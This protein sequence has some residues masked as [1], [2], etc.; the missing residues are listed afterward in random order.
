MKNFIIL[1]LSQIIILSFLISCR[2]SIT[3]PNNDKIED[4][5]PT[6]LTLKEIQYPSERVTWNTGES[7]EIK[8][9]ITENLENVRIILLKKYVEVAIIEAITP[10]D[11]SYYWTIP[12][13][14]SP[15]H[16]YRIRLTPTNYKSA[17]ATSVE[18]EIFDNQ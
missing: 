1:I 2:D 15:S 8:W 4:K 10:N 18:F 6:V 13:N 3:E 7:H 16:H 11:G 12:N 17:Q 9:E 5:N 14:I